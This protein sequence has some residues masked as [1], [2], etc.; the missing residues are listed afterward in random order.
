[1]YLK[2]FFDHF[3]A[4]YTYFN[5]KIT[6]IYTQVKLFE[7]TIGGYLRGILVVI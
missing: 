5:K 7:Q 3:I 4:Y 2:I 1:M 6:V